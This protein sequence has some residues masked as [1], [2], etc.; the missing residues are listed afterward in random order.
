M[1]FT[2]VPQKGIK[3]ALAVRFLHARGSGVFPNNVSVFQ[4]NG[5]PTTNTDLARRNGDLCFDYTNDDIY[6]AS[7]VDAVKG[8]AAS[9][10]TW[11]KIVG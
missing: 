3:K 2:S 7:N 8:T 5:A 10:T 1:A 9:T 11:T 4:K 6:V